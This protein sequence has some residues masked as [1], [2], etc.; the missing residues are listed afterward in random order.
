MPDI[1]GHIAL[2]GGAYSGSSIN[3]RTSS[4]GIALDHQAAG[5]GIGKRT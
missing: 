1:A 4:G 5:A 3:Q 2:H